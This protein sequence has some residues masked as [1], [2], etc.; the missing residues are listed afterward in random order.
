MTVFTTAIR[1][2]AGN[3]A[4]TMISGGAGNLQ[5]LAERAEKF[6]LVFNSVSYPVSYDVSAA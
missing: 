6:C 3:P 1:G 5:E 2:V 4:V